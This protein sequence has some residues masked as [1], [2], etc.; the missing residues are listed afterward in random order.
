[1]GIVLAVILLSLIIFVHELGHFLLAKK[2]G[3][4]VKEFAIGMGPKIIA[5]EVKGTRYALKWI[6]FGGACVMGEEDI[7]DISEGSFNSKPV[8]AR[9]SVIAAGPIFNF[10]LAFAFSVIII[11]I[12]GYEPA[13]IGRISEGFPA[14]EAGLQVGDTITKINGKRIVIYSDITM[15]QW[16]TPLTKDSELEVSYKR[17]GKEYT[18]QLGTKQAEDGRYIMGL[19]GVR[20]EKANVGQAL[21]Y[22]MYNVKFWIEVS[23]RSLQQLVTGKAGVD[24]LAGPI[25]I[26]NVVDDTY[27]STKDEGVL[28]VVLNMLNIATLL[29]ANLGVMN[30]LPIPAMD[31]GR[32]VFLFLEAIRRKRIPTEKE[33]MVHLA[34]MVVLFILMI[35]IL[36]NDVRKLFI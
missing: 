34:G 7:D 22:G 24:D 14:E 29:S 25:G 31:G 5:K 9:I 30:L 10:L 36:F 13:T 11:G 4:R 6:P 26:V 33:G 3:I 35:V 27:Q 8:W 19:S 12:V 23:V 16:F 32:L 2:N 15:Q 1:M 17:D 28:I 20:N 21:K 18:T